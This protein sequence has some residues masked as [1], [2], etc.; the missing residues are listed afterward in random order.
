MKWREKQIGLALGGGGARGFAHIGVLKVLEEVGMP[1]DAVSG[2][3]IGS[4]MGGL[5]ASGYSAAEL[6]AISVSHDWLAMI[7]QDAP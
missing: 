2:T 4:L 3:S 5:Y 6:E 7:G 1:I